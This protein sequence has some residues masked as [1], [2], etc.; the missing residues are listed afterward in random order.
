MIRAV[1]LHVDRALVLVALAAGEMDGL[2]A[3]ERELAILQRAV[4]LDFDLRRPF[5]QSRADRPNAPPITGF[6]PVH[7]G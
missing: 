2:A 5:L 6:I 3:V 1:L 7:A 4:H